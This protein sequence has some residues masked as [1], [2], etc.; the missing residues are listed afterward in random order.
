MAVLPFFLGIFVTLDHRFLRALRL[1]RI[2]KLTR[3]SPA[4]TLL[5]DVLRRR[6]NA[7]PSC[8]KLLPPWT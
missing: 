1:L 3:F 5:V 7:C 8:G 2:F 4:M 6:R